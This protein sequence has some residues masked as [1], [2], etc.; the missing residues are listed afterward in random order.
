MHQPPL[1]VQALSHGDSNQSY[2]IQTAQGDYVLRCYPADSTV[3]RQQELRCQHAAAAKGLAPAPL[4]LNNHYQIMLS[5]YIV[6]A[7]PYR[8]PQQGIEALLQVLV[9][10]HCLQVQTPQLDCL[11]YLEQLQ[12]LASSSPQF[13]PTLFALVQQAAQRLSQHDYDEVLC[14]LD[15]HQGNIVFA[16]SKLWLLD[17]EYSQRADSSLDLAA[18]CWHFQLSEQQ[19]QVMLQHYVS[20][21]QQAALLKPLQQKLPAAK[22]I[23]AGFCWL[24][25]LAQPGCQAQA[26]NWYSLLQQEQ[27]EL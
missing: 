22:I 25:Y 16:D 13:D 9:P 24:W 18:L 5:D 7:E 8:Y 3:C 21:R 4:C 26:A 17:F 27:S 6:G 10:F 14:H 15:L 1:L 20:L 11:T 2:H 12:Y 23:Y 19:Q